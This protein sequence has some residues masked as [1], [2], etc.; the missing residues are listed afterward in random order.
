MALQGEKVL[1]RLLGSS[2]LACVVVLMMLVGGLWL[3]GIF[4]EE[5]RRP[6]TH[7]VDV[8]TPS[9]RLDLAELLG[10]RER[11]L[12]VSP[13]AIETPPLEM[14]PREVRGIVELEFS[15]GPDGSVSDIEVVRATPSGYYEEQARE[16]LME[17]KYAPE[18]QAGRPVTSRRSEVVSFS[19]R[20]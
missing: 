19:V 14:P 7:R 4:D 12:P 18:Q 15:V 20:E 16:L 5:E 3:F 13:R 10:E 1:M 11:R 6:Q 8:L 17:R 2:I 9:E